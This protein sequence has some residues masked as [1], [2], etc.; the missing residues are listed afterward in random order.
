MKLR[1]V[2]LMA[3]AVSMLSYPVLGAEFSVV[4]EM[5]TLVQEQE[6]TSAPLTQMHDEEVT[7]MRKYGE[8]VNVSAVKDE[9]KVTVEYM[10]AD[11][12]T[13]RLLI[14]VE[15][16]DGIPF[17]STQD[18]RIRSMDL[19][20]KRER[21]MDEK[22]AALPKDAP[23]V[24]GFKVMAEY[25]EELKRFIKEDNT[26]D[27]E[28]LIAYFQANAGGMIIGTS[29]GSHGMCQ[30]QE[31]TADKIYFTYQMTTS[32]PAVDEMVLSIANVRG[33]METSQV[34]ATDLVK[35]LSKHQ[36][37]KLVTEPN[38]VEPYELKRLEELKKTNIEDYKMWKEDLESRPKVLLGEG[39][40]GLE[41]VKGDTSCVIDHIGFIDGKLNMRMSGEG[42]ENTYLE[43]YD[44]EGEWVS[45][46][47][48]TGSTS[49]LEDGT[50]KK[51]EYRIFEIGS[52][53]ELEKYTFKVKRRE[54][55]EQ[56]EGP[57]EVPLDMSK[58]PEARVIKVN[59]MIPYTLEEQAF[60]KEVKIGKASLTLVMDQIKSEI[61]NDGMEIKIK[62]KDGL[63]II[64]KYSDASE[65]AGEQLTI[66]YS[67][68]DLVGKDIVSIQIADHIIQVQ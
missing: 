29:G 20:S 18:L 63:E 42:L 50:E 28:G 10:I 26:V 9:V 60:L 16:V 25:N 2:L 19:T 55:V 15:K 8:L 32:T 61:N 24:E 13:T 39:G 7:F 31:N 56:W 11:A 5:G 44:Q 36:K 47:Y 21:E 52:V 35:Y 57:W 33:E 68:K 65:R 66:V 17:K 14:A 1:K 67:S 58:I 27:M 62:C 6:Q 34:I 48:N 54:T 59:E 64:E 53:E 22:L 49:T 43:V 30:T 38:P 40:L 45:A 46:T 4:E 51:E 23:Y 41:L 12:Y 3:L 37:D